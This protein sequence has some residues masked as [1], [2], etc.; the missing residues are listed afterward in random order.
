VRARN[1]A[2]ALR[3]RARLLA[4][5]G[6]APPAPASMLGS[7]AAVPLPA[8]TAPTPRRRDPLHLALGERGFEVPVMRWPGGTGRALRVSAQLYN[9]PDDY[10]RLAQALEALRP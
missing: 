2:L 10:E 5:L 7:L 9:T 4:A 8:L 1:R 6:A 3:A